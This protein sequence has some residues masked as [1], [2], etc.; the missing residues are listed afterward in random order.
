ME[1]RQVLNALSAI[2][3]ETRLD[4]LRRLIVAGDGGLPAGRIA[5]DLGLSASRLSFHLAALEQAGLITARRD[6]RNIYYAADHAGL[7]GVIGYL[8]HDCCGGHPKVCC[9]A[10]HSGDRAAAVPV[11][12]YSDAAGTANI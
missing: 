12:A 3:S 11:G 10:G 7:G 4:L 6:G 8:L 2:A 5:S 1:R 9:S